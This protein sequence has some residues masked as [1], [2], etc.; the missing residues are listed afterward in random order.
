M[1]RSILL[2]SR[3]A[4]L[5]ALAALSSLPALACQQTENGDAEMLGMLAIAALLP[6]SL[7]FQVI[8]AN[9][10]EFQCGAITAKNTNAGAGV[11]VSYAVQDLRFFVSNLRFLDAAGVETPATIVSDGVFQDQ[12][13]GVALLDFEDATA[14]CVGD[15][16]TNRS[17][18]YTAPSGAYTGVA[19]NVGVPEASNHIDRDGADTRSPLNITAMNW[20]WTS[21]YKFAKI[22]LRDGGSNLTNFHLGSTGCAGTP[23][24]GVTCSA[25]NRPE[26]RISDSSG[27]NPAQRRVVLDLNELLRG[28]PQN[29]GALT[30]MPRQG[31]AVCDTLLDTLGVNGATG[32][33]NS[34]SVEAFRVSQ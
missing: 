32:A 27:F 7:S 12:Q 23:P 16:R 33:S 6:Q 20:A 22:E 26:V 13:Y 4:L 11:A 15:S 1:Y 10:V 8:D 3:R 5:F 2:Q 21:G 17:V 19:F 24:S 9:A 30:C 31:G 29:P 28:F 18:R 34:A 14:G 25:A